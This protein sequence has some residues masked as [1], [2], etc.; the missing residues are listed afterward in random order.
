MNKTNKCILQ[1]DNKKAFKYGC[2]ALK[3][4]ATKEMITTGKCGTY[5]CPFYKESVGECR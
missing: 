5:E 3:D 2:R 4:E 1:S